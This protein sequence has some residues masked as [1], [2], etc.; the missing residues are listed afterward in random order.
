MMVATGVAVATYSF[1]SGLGVRA[2]GT[3]MG[4]QACVE[5]ITG[6]GMVLYALATRRA[7]LPACRYSGRCERLT[8]ACA[9]PLPHKSVGE[10]HD[11]ACWNPL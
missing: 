10:R 9:Q 1:F 5:I 6:L 2:A 11:V 8:E 7:D 4:F 3:V